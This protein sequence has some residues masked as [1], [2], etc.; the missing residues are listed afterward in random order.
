MGYTNASW[1]LKC[2]L[3]AEYVCRL[4]NYMDEHNHHMATPRYQ[5]DP[6]ATEPLLDFSSGYVRRAY[7]ILPKQGKNSPWRIH[8]NYI[9]D[10]LEMR[11][12]KI[13]NDHM[14]FA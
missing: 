11:T 13:K 2:D 4:I 9:K 10:L 6:T 7:G 1:T 8:Q 12:S 14:E 5:G 3:T